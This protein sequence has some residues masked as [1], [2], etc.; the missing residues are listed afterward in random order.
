MFNRRQAPAG[1]L[2]ATIAGAV[3]FAAVPVAAQDAHGVIAFGETGE[4]NGVAYGFSWNFPGKEAAH[5]EAVNACISTGGTDCIQLAW[6]Q[7]GCGALAMDQYGNAQGKP[8]MSREQAEARAL[9]T[10]EAAGGGGCNIVGSVCAAPGGE[11]GTWSGSEGVLPAHGSQPTPTGPEDESLTREERIRIQQSLTALGFD[12]GPADGVFGR[13]TRSAIWEW[14][15]ANGLEAT[16]HVTREQFASMTAVDASATEEREP[17][18]RQ[19]TADVQDYN[20]CMGYCTRGK[21]FD[22]CHATCSNSTLAKPSVAVPA[23]G[24]RPVAKPPA[25]VPAVGQGNC[26]APDEK[27]DAIEENF[28]E[29]YGRQVY[30]GLSILGLDEDEQFKVYFYHEQ[31]VCERKVSVDKDCQIGDAEGT[32]LTNAELRE[33]TIRC[34]LDDR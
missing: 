32:V 26:T 34:K 23:A 18:P 7:N 16:G 21:D 1:S 10:C 31:Q 6:F 20:V 27:M 5:A 2:A 30:S 33:Q 12:A 4:G 28:M 24:H 8:G 19:E 17:E 9:R 13:R 15:N 14:Q 29:I 3:L 25:A 22:H 11:P